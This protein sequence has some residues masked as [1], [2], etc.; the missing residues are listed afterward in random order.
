[1]IRNLFALTKMTYGPN[2]AM[3]I[4]RSKLHPENVH[5]SFK[6]LRWFDPEYDQK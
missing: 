2:T 1:M 5:S 6:R 3:V 4:Y